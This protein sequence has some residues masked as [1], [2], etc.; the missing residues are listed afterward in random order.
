MEKSYHCAGNWGRGNAMP[1]AGSCTGAGLRCV[2]CG[3]RG[4]ASRA[5]SQ[6]LQ[7]ARTA[8]AL[9]CIESVGGVH[10]EKNVRFSQHEP[11]TEAG[12]DALKVII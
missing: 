1:M 4:L 6:C 9:F 8:L 5:R 2:S 3:I 10:N 7:N 11:F 12:G